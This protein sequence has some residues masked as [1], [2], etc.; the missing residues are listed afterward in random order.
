MR[1]RAL[2]YFLLVS[3]CILPTGCK[4]WST[5]PRRERVIRFSGYNWIVKSSRHLTGP[6]PNYFSDRA[7][8][9]WVDNRG[10]LHLKI[11]WAGGHW[12]CSEV[13]SEKLFGYGKYTFKLASRVDYLDPSAVAGFFTWYPGG[14]SNHRELDI[15]FSRW[16]RIQELNGQYVVQPAEKSGHLYP[17][18][19]KQNGT[20]TTHQFVWKPNMIEFKSMHG[21]H[22]KQ[23]G[24]LEIAHWKFRRW[25]IPKGKNV[26]ARIN[27]W[28]YRGRPPL[29]SREIELIIQEFNYTPL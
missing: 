20:F 11:K 15:E 18:S 28:L 24:Q 26:Q 21:H 7:D 29:Y 1:K 12:Q 22:D 14:F 4:M 17:F 6:G 8:Q 10:C 5:T 19:F 9:V 27:L 2:F 23:N 3:T 25:G 16:G 13:I